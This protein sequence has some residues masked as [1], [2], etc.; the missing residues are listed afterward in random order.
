MSKDKNQESTAKD[1]S[2]VK[3][4]TTEV[5]SSI[6]GKVITAPYLAAK[7]FNIPTK[8]IKKKAK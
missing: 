3:P 5:P 8:A 6:T 4:T 7:A 2:K 1:Q